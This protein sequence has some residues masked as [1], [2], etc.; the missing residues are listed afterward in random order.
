MAL[1]LAKTPH[2][3]LRKELFQCPVGEKI[4]LS[5]CT[6][7]TILTRKYGTQERLD[8]KEKIFSAG[9]LTLISLISNTKKKDVF[10][11]QFCWWSPRG[12]NDLLHKICFL[13]LQSFLRPVLPI[14][15]HE[16]F[17]YKE[18]RLVSMLRKSRGIS[19]V[20]LLFLRSLWKHKKKT[21]RDMNIDYYLA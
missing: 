8:Q 13:L 19:L 21:R 7:I 15:S 14:L 17:T 20:S 9:G 3:P 18:V 16:K 6:K 12:W 10:F 2:L 11:F 5:V 4:A 1:Q